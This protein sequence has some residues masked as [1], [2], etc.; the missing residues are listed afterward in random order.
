M[1]IMRY[2][3]FKYWIRCVLT[4][5]ALGAV[6]MAVQQG[7]SRHHRPDVQSAS[8]APAQETRALPD[9]AREVELP[10]AEIPPA[11][12]PKEPSAV[13]AGANVGAT[14]PPTSVA[15]P[16]KETVVPATV[17][18]QTIAPRLYRAVKTAPNVVFVGGGSSA[19]S[20]TPTVD[21]P[22]AFTADPQNFTP[23]HQTA[24]AQI[25]NEFLKTFGDVNQDPGDPAYRKRWMNAQNLAD[26]RFR[27]LFGWTAFMRLDL[28]RAR[29]TYTEIQPP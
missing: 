25:Q 21:P 20:A 26:E 7:M 22:L 2:F 28:E 23:E 11:A 8:P 6:W 17:S 19:T 27:V 29:N 1:N 16:A 15:A 9:T 3:L 4:L 12:R 18:R 13:S 14:V 24:L 10:Q 5:V